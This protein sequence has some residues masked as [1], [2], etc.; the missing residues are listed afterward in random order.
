[1]AKRRGDIARSEWA[2]LGLVIP[3]N[4]TKLTYNLLGGLEWRFLAPRVRARRAHVAYAEVSV[5]AKQLSVQ[6][7]NFDY[8]RPY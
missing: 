8:T 1:M 3:D 4:Q 2:G 6:V 7:Q 5:P